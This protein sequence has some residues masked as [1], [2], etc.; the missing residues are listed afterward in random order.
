[1]A[2]EFE[3]ERG[4]DEPGTLAEFLE[5]VALV[6]D[7]DQIPD[8]DEDGA[9]RHHADDPAHRQGPGVPG[10][11]PHRHGGRRLPAHAR[12]RPD[13]GA[14]GGA[15]A[16]VRRHHARA[17]AALPD[18]V[19]AAQRVGPALVQPAL[20]LPGGDPGAARGVE[21]DGRDRRR[22]AGR[23]GRPG[24]RPRCPRPRSRSVGVG[25]VAA[26]RRRR[27]RGTSRWSRWRS[28]TG[29]RT[30]SSG[31]ARSSA[32]DGHGRRTRRRRSTSATSKP[33]RLLLRYAPVEKL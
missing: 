26:S 9:R 29:S 23:P 6:A 30:T 7:S 22:R 10:G 11:L 13:Q 33:K 5:R 12:P 24:W 3:Q 15:A 25:R 18:P 16:G 17:R 27:D 14:G 19:G 20:A 28:A 8:E 32:V 2:L 1:M 4:E 31:S 21:A